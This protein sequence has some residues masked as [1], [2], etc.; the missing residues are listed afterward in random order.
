[1]YKPKNYQNICEKLDSHIKTRWELNQ[2]KLIE[3]LLF[4][5]MLPLHK[6]NFERQLALYSVGIQRLNEVLD[7]F[8]KND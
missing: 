4:I 3:G 8:G 2:I 6:D 1:V 7:N 5:S